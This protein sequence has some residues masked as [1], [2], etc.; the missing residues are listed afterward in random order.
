MNILWKNLWCL[1]AFNE[2]VWLLIW[3]KCFFCETSCV[4]CVSCLKNVCFFSVFLMKMMILWMQFHSFFVKNLWF[5]WENF[6]NNSEN[7]ST[8]NHQQTVRVSPSPIKTKFGFYR[9]GWHPYRLLVIFRWFVLRIIF[10]IFSEKSQIFYKKTMKLHPQNHHFHQ[11][12]TKKT[13][14]FQTT[15]TKNTWSFTKKTFFSYQKSYTF[16]KRSQTS[17]VFSQNV[18]KSFTKYLQRSTCFFK[19]TLNVIQKHNVFCRKSA[20]VLQNNNTVFLYLHEKHN[21]I[22]PFSPNPRVSN[23]NKKQKHKR[24]L[25]LV[26]VTFMKMCSNNRFKSSRE[27]FGSILV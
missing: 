9:A 14:V 22:S 19:K 10:E 20:C 5:F 17:Q 26:W 1:W 4:F 11:K 24:F 8:K 13:Y 15:N 12:N 25:N 6:K 18:H 27:W 16:I 7:K 23:K 2:S 3:K 21:D